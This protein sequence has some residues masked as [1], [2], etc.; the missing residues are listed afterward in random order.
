[1]PSVSFG[2]FVR[3]STQKLPVTKA[4]V[5]S[6]N[7]ILSLYPPEKA[8]S[9]DV[10]KLKQF[11]SSFLMYFNPKTAEEHCTANIF[12]GIIIKWLLT[13][14]QQN[15]DFYKINATFN[16]LHLLI[17]SPLFKGSSIMLCG[18]LKKIT[19]IVCSNYTPLCVNIPSL[20]LQIFDVAINPKCELDVQSQSLLAPVIYYICEKIISTLGGKKTK[21]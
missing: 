10:F 6:L 16:N 14:A 12:V 3:V 11:L 7:V 21:A 2:I 4:I 19:D 5:E 15:Y 1:M 17:K 20:L 18:S 13:S 9:D 8:S